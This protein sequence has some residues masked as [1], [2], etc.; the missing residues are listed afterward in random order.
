[1]R[2]VAKS[3]WKGAARTIYC[4]YY[5]LWLWMSS[6]LKWVITI[7]LTSNLPC[8]IQ[9][10]DPMHHTA[11]RCSPLL[12]LI[13]L[14]GSIAHWLAESRNLAAILHASF[15]LSCYPSHIIYPWERSVNSHSESGLGPVHFSPCFCF[16]SFSNNDPSSSWNNLPA[17]IYTAPSGLGSRPHP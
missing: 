7:S 14:S 15:C 12:F 8:Q 10:L 11:R 16:C 2:G 13:S 1:M 17:D 6:K 9:T 5:A 4:R 3:H